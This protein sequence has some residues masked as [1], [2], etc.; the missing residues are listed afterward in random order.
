MKP[1]SN[2]TP[3]ILSLVAVLVPAC[4][5]HTGIQDS[6]KQATLAPGD[7][8]PRV[9]SRPAIEST[10]FDS[11]MNTALEDLKHG[12]P[13]ALDEFLAG[14]SDAEQWALLEHAYEALHEH[15]TILAGFIG[16]KSMT[17]KMPSSFAEILYDSLPSI[18]SPKEL[19]LQAAQ[20]GRGAMQE[21][22]FSPKFRIASA[23]MRSGDN[24]TLTRVWREFAGLSESDQE[25]IA[26][27]ADLSQDLDQVFA[28]ASAARVAKSEEIQII[29]LDAASRM[30]AHSLADPARR[31]AAQ[32]TAQQMRSSGIARPLLI[33]ALAKLEQ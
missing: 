23:I 32:R 31:E 14:R 33:D 27:V 26:M 11:T 7:E 28:V 5:D 30:V 6:Q 10:P 1:Y 22:F 15:W 19:S 3:I 21:I 2:T 9:V 25:L 13:K 20:R 8:K 29:L 24:P 16:P 12:D 18:D 4:R 17:S